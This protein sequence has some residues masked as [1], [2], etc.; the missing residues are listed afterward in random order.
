[1]TPA[2]RVAQRNLV[3]A[4]SCQPA[5]GASITGVD[6]QRRRSPGGLRRSRNPSPRE[7]LSSLRLCSVRGAG[8]YG[9]APRTLTVVA[10]ESRKGTLGPHLRRCRVPGRVVAKTASAGLSSLLG[11]WSFSF[12]SPAV[13][14]WFEHFSTNP[15][16]AGLA[17]VLSSGL[18]SGD[19]L[20]H[21]V[22]LLPSFRGSGTPHGNELRRTGPRDRPI[23]CPGRGP[24]ASVL[25]EHGRCDSSI[26][27]A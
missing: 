18:L 19:Y 16:E 10:P 13:V 4:R 20:Q 14:E 26:G 15:G 23:R 7:A 11:R 9:C 5:S 12:S 2:E 8:R 22:D 6:R 25:G 21:L 27:M 17:T 24:A 3:H 1:M